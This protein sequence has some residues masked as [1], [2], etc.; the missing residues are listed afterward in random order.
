MVRVYLPLIHVT[1]LMF[2]TITLVIT[3][4]IQL[5]I[6]VKYMYIGVMYMYVCIN[7]LFVQ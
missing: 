7:S 5:L 3:G 1:S 6:M 2:L 4:N